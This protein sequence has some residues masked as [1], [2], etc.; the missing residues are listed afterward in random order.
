VEK[1]IVTF[2]LS[3]AWETWTVEVPDGTTDEE[4]LNMTA[5]V[6]FV[7]M[8]ESGNNSMDAIEVEDA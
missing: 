7:C 5:D 4:I 2:A 8:E 6:E 3:A 1:K